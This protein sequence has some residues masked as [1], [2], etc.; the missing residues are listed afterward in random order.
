MGTIIGVG[1]TIG[2]LGS[3][4]KLYLTFSCEENQ[5][6]VGQI[7]GTSATS[8]AV[9]QGNDTFT[10][11]NTGLIE[12]IIAPD[13]EIQNIYTLKVLSSK[14]VTYSITVNVTDVESETEL[15]VGTNLLFTTTF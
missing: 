4:L 12:F 9:I 8:F 13:Y 7:T 2:G 11:D 3:K 14:G 15:L 6:T 5:T 10:V 1:N